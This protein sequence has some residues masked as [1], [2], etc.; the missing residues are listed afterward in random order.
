MVAVGPGVRRQL[1][2]PQ[3]RFNVRRYRGE[4]LLSK[5][6]QAAVRRIRQRLAIDVRSAPSKGVMPSR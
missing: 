5:L 4:K 6:S 2:S 3:S 1:K